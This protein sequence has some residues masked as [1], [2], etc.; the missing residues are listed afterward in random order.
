MENSFRQL[1][2]LY[3][4]EVT[5]SLDD[6]EEDYDFFTRSVLTDPDILAIL[7]N[8]DPPTMEDMIERQ[9]RIK[10]F[11]GGLVEINPEIQSVILLSK[12]QFYSWCIEPDTIDKTELGRQPWLTN[13]TQDSGSPFFVTEAHDRSYY[14]KNKEGVMIT[15]GRKIWNYH[16]AEAGVILFDIYPNRL[17]KLSKEF[18]DMNVK[19]SI[20]LYI[21]GREGKIVYDSDAIT[22][23]NVWDFDKR[24]AMQGETQNAA[25]LTMM[26]A[27]S[28]GRLLAVIAIP[29]SE[30][31]K[32]INAARLIVFALDAALGL[33]IIFFAVKYSLKIDL[34]IRKLRQDMLEARLQALQGQINPHMLYN[35]FES[36]RMKAVVNNQDEIAEMIKVLARMFKHSLHSGEQENRINDELRY[37]KDYLYMQNIWYDNRFVFEEHLSP[38]VLAL[39]I[40][41]MVFQPIIEN[42]IKHGFHNKPSPLHI[43]IEEEVGLVREP[44]LVSRT[45]RD[46][47]GQSL[48]RPRFLAEVG[49]TLF[50]SRKRKFPNDSV[51]SASFIRISITDDGAGASEEKVKEINLG[52]T[53]IGLK[54]VSERLRL[55]YGKDSSLTVSSQEGHFFKVELVIPADKNPLHN[56]V[57]TV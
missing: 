13:H 2:S 52:K 30:L 38:A 9:T 37:V 57:Y 39:P 53:G 16:G 29:L 34:P 24:I 36:I 23:K 27:S 49:Q 11:F 12:N 46:F 4:S 15:V 26:D 20:T 21:T 51:I 32:K 3:V 28:S 42:C 35:T 43:L 45:S 10:S 8:D 7:G 5:L 14:T 41:P 54:N 18:L 47:S 55:W 50:G 22:G 31:F 44:D 48:T 6:F 56:G 17:V 33:I 25:S 1:A 19:N 40:I